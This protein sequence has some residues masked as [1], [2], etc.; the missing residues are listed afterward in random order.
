MYTAITCLATDSNI[1]YMSTVVCSVR[2]VGACIKSGLSP[3][4][5]HIV[6]PYLLVIGSVG[7]SGIECH[8]TSR[9]ESQL[10]AGHLSIDGGK[11]VI[12]DGSPD[13]VVADLQSSC[14][15]VGPSHQPEVKLSTGCDIE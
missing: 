12:A 2:L 3:P 9:R 13:V 4:A 7:E 1:F 11:E 10:P 8:C 14:H 15:V 5:A 6:K